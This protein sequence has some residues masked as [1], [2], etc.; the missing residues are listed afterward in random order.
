[1]PERAREGASEGGRKM[2]GRRGRQGGRGREEEKRRGRQ[3]RQKGVECM[4]VRDPSDKGRW[5]G[6]AVG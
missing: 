4:M 2:R 6:G 5:G 3:R 1:M